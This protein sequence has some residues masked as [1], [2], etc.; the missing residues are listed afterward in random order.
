MIASHVVNIVQWFNKFS[1]WVMSEICNWSDANQRALCIKFFLRQVF[2]MPQIFTA[3]NLFGF[4]FSSIWPILPQSPPPRFL[5]FS[6]LLCDAQGVRGVPEVTVPLLLAPHSNNAMQP[7]FT[8]AGTATTTQSKQ[9][10][11]ASKALPFSGKHTTRASTIIMALTIIR[12]KQTWDL[13]AE[14]YVLA[15]FN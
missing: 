10:L 11:P 9:S 2:L 3:V 6:S 13:V 15:C 4:T 1:R 7:H 12:L 8:S 14:K 5:P